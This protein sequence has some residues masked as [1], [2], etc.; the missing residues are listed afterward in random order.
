MGIEKPR[1]KQTGSLFC[2]TS[3]DFDH[4]HKLFFSFFFMNGLRKR[5]IIP[6]RIK[7]Y[8]YSYG[9]VVING[10]AIRST[11]ELT[12]QVNQGYVTETTESYRNVNVRG[13]FRLYK[14][15]RRYCH[16]ILIQ[17]LHVSPRSKMPMLFNFSWLFLNAKIYICTKQLQDEKTATW[18]IWNGRSYRKKQPSKLFRS[19]WSCVEKR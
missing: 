10:I 13:L 1:K 9:T 5:R 18:K 19:W 12:N 11:K 7:L 3:F 2:K 6:F 4:I 16:E 8:R 15:R 14:E 17:V